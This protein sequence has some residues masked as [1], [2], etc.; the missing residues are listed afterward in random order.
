MTGVQTCA[1]PISR[2]ATTVD[3]AA[4][5]RGAGLRTG[6]AVGLLMLA[7][8]A[9]DRTAT[10]APAALGLLFVALADPGG[11]DRERV[12]IMARTAAFTTAAV[13]LGVLAAGPLPRHVAVAMAVAVVCGFAGAIGPRSGF[14]GVLCLVLFV[15]FAG[16]PAGVSVAA[17]DALRYAS[18]AGIAVAVLAVIALAD[19]SR[20]PRE[21]LARMLRGLGDAD[22]SDP[23]S[24]G[25]PVH[26]LRERAFLG[27]ARADR[28]GSAR[29]T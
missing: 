7:A 11:A 3:R 16:G 13:M 4:L 26:A 22:P 29:D 27:A 24:L 21:A 6:L 17:G 1:L 25:A 18:G 23:I 14:G 5:D 20:G 2:A 10:S 12:T 28:A 9:A 19:R 15:I 8:V